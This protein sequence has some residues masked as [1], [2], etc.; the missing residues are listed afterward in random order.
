M[1]TWQ[2][3]HMLHLRGLWPFIFNLTIRCKWNVK[4]LLLHLPWKSVKRKLNEKRKI[5][6]KYNSKVWLVIWEDLERMSF[7]EK[8]WNFYRLIK[9]ANAFLYTLKVSEFGKQ[10]CVLLI[11]TNVFT[12]KDIS[13]YVRDGILVW[14]AVVLNSVV[15]ELGS[16]FNSLSQHFFMRQMSYSTVKSQ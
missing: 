11:I 14:A 1:F 3:L 7:R 4:E 5:S 12:G 15:Y 2:L 6:K 9:N 10:N 13:H 16:N 8:V